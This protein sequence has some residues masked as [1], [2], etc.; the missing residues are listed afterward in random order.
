[1]ATVIL[2]RDKVERRTG[3]SRSAI[4]AKL[5]ENPNRPNDY[6]PTFPKPI[7]LGSQAVGWVESEIE[8]WLTAQ[9]AKSRQ[10][11]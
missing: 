7:R 8:E 10:T 4:Y 5:K 2:R 1:M 11:A 3:L 9:I 6:D